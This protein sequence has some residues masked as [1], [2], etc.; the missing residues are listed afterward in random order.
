MGY[1]ACNWF[2]IGFTTN[3]CTA[4]LCVASV[5]HHRVCSAHH[6]PGVVMVPDNPAA[7]YDIAGCN[8]IRVPQQQ[9][10]APTSEYHK[11]W[12]KSLTEPNCKG[13]APLGHW[14]CNS[15]CR[16]CFTINPGITCCLIAPLSTLFITSRSRS[17][18][19]A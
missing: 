13:M 14:V 10:L 5:C 9:C 3:P 7:A 12:W 19:G 6:G 1:R 11:N 8:H 4:V 18:D 15:S 2:G 17:R 16:C